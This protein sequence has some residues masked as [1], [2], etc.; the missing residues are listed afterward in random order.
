MVKL[1][2]PSKMPCYSW[3]LQAIDT[4]PASTDSNGAL[5]D[6]CAGCYAT[7]GNYYFPHVIAVRT[8]NKLD[9][10]RADWVADMVAA[11]QTEQ[12]FRWFDSGDMYSLLL[13]D[14][15]YQIM[16][17]TP[18]CRH[19]LPTRMHKFRKFRPIIRA[20]QALPNVVVRLSAD[21]VTGKVLPHCTTST[22][23]SNPL[24][25]AGKQV[26]PCMAYTR[27][28]KCGECR[29]CWDKSVKVIAYPA[30]GNNMR[31]VIRLKNIA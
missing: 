28:G 5:V 22:I 18:H 15:I 26:T 14:R 2:K 16:Q 25:L 13:A 9:W 19:W 29:A 30:H 31:K 17:A 27:G 3:S 11:L 23:F 12:L 24:Q 1:S 4:C 20:M 6:A 21:S 7:Q 10:Q 8:Y